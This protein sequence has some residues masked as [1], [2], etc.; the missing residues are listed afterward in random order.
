M[1]LTFHAG[2]CFPTGHGI[3]STSK[4][5]N[6]TGVQT[7]LTVSSRMAKLT[8]GG[9]PSLPNISTQSKRYICSP[10]RVSQQAVAYFP[11]QTYIPSYPS[12]AFFFFPFSHLPFFPTPSRSPIR[13]GADHPVPLLAHLG[14]V[15]LPF[16]FPDTTTGYGPI[17]LFFDCPGSLAQVSSPGALFRDFTPS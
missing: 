10:I 8:L 6:P 9:I 7:E 12:S 2:L 4:L 5:K 15:G 1:L 3:S 16:C 17:L 11:Y 13:P 14:A